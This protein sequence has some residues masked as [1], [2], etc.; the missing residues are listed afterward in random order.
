MHTVYE[1]LGMFTVN[2]AYASFEESVKGSIEEGKL[3]H[4]TVV[5]VARGQLR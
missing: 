3:A 1:A 5:S 4:V 2:A